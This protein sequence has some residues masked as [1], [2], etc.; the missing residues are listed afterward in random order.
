MG[1][2]IYGV[3]SVKKFIKIPQRKLLSGFLSIN[4]RNHSDNDTKDD[5]VQAAYDDSG[6]WSGTDWD[7][8]WGYPFANVRPDDQGRDGYKHSFADYD[9][10]LFFVAGGMVL[11]AP[12]FS[13]STVSVANLDAGGFDDNTV[14]T[15]YPSAQ[16][17]HT[18]QHFIKYHLVSRINNA[19]GFE[20]TDY[21][22]HRAMR[23]K[24]FEAD[25]E[26]Y[27]NAD[28]VKEPVD[29]E[30][31]THSRAGVWDRYVLSNGVYDGEDVLGN[32]FTPANPDNGA[33]DTT[34]AH[35]ASFVAGNDLSTDNN[36][37]YFT[38]VDK[39]RIYGTHHSVMPVQAA[40]S[41]GGGF[42]TGDIVFSN[43]GGLGYLHQQDFWNLVIEVGMRGVHDG[44]NDA[45]GPSSTNYE[46]DDEWIKTRVNVFFQPFGETA[47]FD[48]ADSLHTS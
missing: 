7:R 27:D 19:S 35:G 18:C 21:Y 29:F 39:I 42:S 3:S 45:S 43:R 36:N 14:D 46:A 33:A 4:V 48:V 28:I 2:T 34:F 24:T 8:R 9:T 31:A 16:V 38:P 10:F 11:D 22:K 23:T 6:L 17:S 13:G 41:S 30:N 5:F 37:T 15:W 44:Y 26:T 20:V 47:S 25:D 12:V 1:A 40:G 32:S